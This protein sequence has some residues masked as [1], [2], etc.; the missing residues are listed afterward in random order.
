MSEKI[1]IGIKNS[2][3][4]NRKIASHVAWNS[5]EMKTMK[6]SFKKLTGF[7]MT[8]QDKFPVM[9]D[10]FSW[11]AVARKYGVN[12]K[13]AETSSSFTQVLRAGVQSV[14]NQS[15]ETVDTSYE[16]WVHTVQ[17]SKSEELYAPLQGISFLREVGKQ[18]VY[19]EVRA[20][21]LDIKLRNRKFGAMFAVE[22]ELL[23]DDQTGQF[24]KQ[25]GLMGQYCKIL[26]EVYCMGKLASVNGMAYDSLTIPKSETQPTEE[27]TY[28]WATALVG[29]GKNRPS[30]Y[31]ALI[32]AN[33]QNGFIG[34]RQQ[35][36]K[37]GLK[38]M[39]KPD[40]LLIGSTYE[41]DASVLLNS[42][43][44]PSVQ[45]AAGT[46]GTN[47]AINPIKG[48][49]SLTVSRFMFKNDGTVAGDS[50]AWYLM[51]S[52]VPWFILQLRAAPEVQQ[53]NPAAGQSFE[54]DVV[55]FKVSMRA[56]A[57]HIDPRFAWQGNDGSV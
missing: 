56:N 57:D 45:G 34:L 55:R 7:E 52:S 38:M 17:S 12:L 51:D 50:K 6:E 29:G 43:Y 44:Y 20:A 46:A 42:A 18:E 27:A 9:N 53:E 39:V 10:R 3:E 4:T 1:K 31:G 36:N 2:A 49:A 8:D 22:K 14:V 25:A 35:L 32:Q 33:I 23:E 41:F 24:A 21:G 54:K 11:A 15:Y 28:P 13:E 30:S 37:L 40:R 16:D 48:I 19:P 47:Y 26:L 5:P